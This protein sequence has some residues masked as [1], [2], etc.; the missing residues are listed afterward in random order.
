MSPMGDDFYVADLAL[1]FGYPLIVVAKNQIGVI[2]QTVQTLIAARHF[3]SGVKV[4]GIVLNRTTPP[5]DDPSIADN[6]RQ[7]ELHCEAP[8]LAEVAY[9]QTGFSPAIDWA[10][11]ATG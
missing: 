9:G 11:V 5:D 3:R 1:E 4:A 2:N 7:L 10:A 8:V 6:R